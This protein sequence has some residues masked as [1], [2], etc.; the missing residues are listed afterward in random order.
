MTQCSL[1]GS[2]NR[3]GGIC[4]L[5][6]Q[7]TNSGNH[8]QDWMVSTHKTTVERPY[9]DYFLRHPRTQVS[10]LTNYVTTVTTSRYASDG[11]L[12][13]NLFFSSLISLTFLFPRVTQSASKYFFT[14]DQVLGLY[15]VET[16]IFRSLPTPLH[17]TQLFTFTGI[18]DK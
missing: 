9:Y 5:H 7:S 11:R 3:F 8:I 13:F 18:R 14:V 16:L 15:A 12:K 6:L 1:T 17:R 10:A 4:C 2:Y